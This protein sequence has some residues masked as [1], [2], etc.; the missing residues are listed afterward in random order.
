M[1]AERVGSPMVRNLLLAGFLGFVGSAGVFIVIYMLD[2]KLK[3]AENIQCT[4][5]LSTLGTIPFQRQHEEVK[6]E[7]ANG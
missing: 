4:L 7:N 5:G 1:P 3:T 2:D 6:E